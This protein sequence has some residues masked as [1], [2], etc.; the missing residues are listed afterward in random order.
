MAA[1]INPQQARGMSEQTHEEQ[2]DIE[3]CPRHPAKE[4]RLHCN[5]CGRLMC[6]Q[7]AVQTPTGYRCVDCVKEQQKV[8]IT[9]LPQDYII[10]PLVAAILSLIGG[11]IISRLWIYFILFGAPFLGGVIA[12]A[13]RRVI[14]RRRGKSLF[15]AI[16]AGIFVGGIAPALIPLAAA[17]FLAGPSGL[18]ESLAFFGSSLLWSL[19]YAVLAAGAAYYRLSGLRL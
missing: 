3:Y 17:L 9:A 19:V 7:C 5:R 18:I 6:T 10:G 12:E 11:L 2:H 8:F 13:A 4:A 1:E 14:G 15:Q 16:T